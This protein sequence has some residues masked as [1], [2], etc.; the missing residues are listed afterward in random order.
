MFGKIIYYD[1]KTID[2]YKSI[3]NGRKPLEIGEDFERSLFFE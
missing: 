3:I 1:K 2:E